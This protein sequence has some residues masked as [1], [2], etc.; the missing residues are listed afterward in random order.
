M[1]SCIILAA[2]LSTRFGSP[3]P[4]AN[5]K[6]TTVIEYLQKTLTDSQVDEI[7]IVLGAYHEEIKTH[8]LNHKKIKVVY[9][10][11]YNLGQTSSFKTGLRHTLEDS[12]GIMLLPA[13]YPVVRRETIDLLIENFSKQKTLMLIPTHHGKKGHPP[14]FHGTLTETILKM[15]DSSGLN[16]LAKQNAFEVRLLEVDDPGI[17]YTFNNPE[18]LKDLLNRLD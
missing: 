12:D 15:D 2:G 16:V 4:L 1:T 13:D 11:D 17:L 14:I 9:N 3:K 8:I 5:L 18:E 6:G 10:K 7:I